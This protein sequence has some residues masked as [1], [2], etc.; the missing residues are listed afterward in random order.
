MQTFH[1]LLPVLIVLIT[2]SSYHR[3]NPVR[4]IS[5]EV[6]DEIRKNLALFVFIGEF[7]EK[8]P[9]LPFLKV[10]FFNFSFAIEFKVI[11]SVGGEV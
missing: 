3:P 9:V 10:F 11:I 6:S 7:L 2:I 8:I 4:R 1:S 5:D